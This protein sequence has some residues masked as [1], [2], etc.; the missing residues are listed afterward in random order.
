MDPPDCIMV[1]CTAQAGD[2]ENLAVSLVNAR[3]AACVNVVDVRSCF[4]WEGAV[5]TEDERLLIMKTQHRLLDPLIERIRGQH[6]YD[7]PEIIAIPIIGGDGPYLN[8]IR[9]ETG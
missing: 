1:F 5:S 6:T 7:L 9:E 2:A 3:L 4:W 8:W